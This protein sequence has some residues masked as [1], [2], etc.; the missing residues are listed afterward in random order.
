MSKCTHW[1]WECKRGCTTKCLAENIYCPSNGTEGMVFESKFCD[2]CIHENAELQK[3]CDLATNA[4][5]FHPTEREF[6]I[7]WVRSGNGPSCTSYVQWDWNNDGDPGDPNN[8]KAPIVPIANQ[9]NLFPLY[10]TE[11]FFKPLT[12][13]PCKSQMTPGS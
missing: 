6:P 7:E 4:H 8:P 3:Y 5:F 2:H 10:P 13:T 9:L 11:Q 1:P 12:I